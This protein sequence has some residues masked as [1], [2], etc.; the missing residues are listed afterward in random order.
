VTGTT[1]GIGG[2]VKAVASAHGHTI[3]ELNRADFNSTSQLPNFPTSQLPNI[4]T[5]EHSN[6]RTFLDALIFCTGTCPIRSVAL[7]ADELL[8]ETVRLNCGLFLSLMRTIVA[9]KLYNPEGMK[10]VAISS[11]SAREGWAGGAAYCASKGALSA[12][13]RAMDVELKVKKI[14]VK[15]IEPRYVRTKMFDAGAGRMGVPTSEAR[16]P[17]DLAEE[18]L[19]EIEGK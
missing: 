12:M 9:E 7:T 18:I 5:F 15:A 2:A 17:T 13:C 6:I 19:A 11:V 1:G 3:F 4:R 10:A 8:A 16:D 14:S